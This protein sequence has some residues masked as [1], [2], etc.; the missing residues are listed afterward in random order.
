VLSD[1][2]LN[3]TFAAGSIVLIDA[4]TTAS[5]CAAGRTG[6]RRRRSD[7]TVRDVGRLAATSQQHPE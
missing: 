6:S 1:G 7:E 5:S 2:L 3:G 4:G